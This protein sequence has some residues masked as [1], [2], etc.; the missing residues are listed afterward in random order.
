MK[1]MYGLTRLIQH[2]WQR[3]PL[4]LSKGNLQRFSLSCFFGMFMLLLLYLLHQIVPRNV[5]DH[6]AMVSFVFIIVS[7]L[8]LFPAQHKLLRFFL[9]KN[10]T[11]YPSLFGGDLLETEFLTRPLSID[12]L[13]TNAFP[14]MLAW[15][16]APDAGLAILQS[17]RSF[18]QYYDYRNHKLADQWTI[19]RKDYDLLCKAL[20]KKSGR[21]WST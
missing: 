21:Y 3:K 13:L 5:P 17:N 19:A 1:N 8:L 4:F 14:D 10:E 18:Y 20:A 6:S 9:R 7:V 11:Q 16:G 15:L 2:K 12:S